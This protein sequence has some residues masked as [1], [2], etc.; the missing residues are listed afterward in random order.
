MNE[1]VK[2][3]LDAILER[4]KSGDIPEVVSYAMFPIPD[5]PSSRWSL[6]PYHN[7]YIRNG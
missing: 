2:Q 4:F 7:V 3:T 6:E 5:L 1:R